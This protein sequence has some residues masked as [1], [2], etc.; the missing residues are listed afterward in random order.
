MRNKNHQSSVSSADTKAIVP[1][2]TTFYKCHEQKS[3]SEHIKHSLS[4]MCKGRR[5]HWVPLPVGQEPESEAVF[6][7]I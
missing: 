4:W 2:I 1:Q 6:M 3:I 7:R 5:T